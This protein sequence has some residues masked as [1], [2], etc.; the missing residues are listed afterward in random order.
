MGEGARGCW[1]CVAVGRGESGGKKRW[2]RI[3]C[4]E[5]YRIGLSVAHR[6][7]HASYVCVSVSVCMCVCV[8]G[9]VEVVYNKLSIFSYNVSYKSLREGIFLHVNS[10]RM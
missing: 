6:S 8:G 10:E 2:C 4:R 5:L 9:G 1:E 3:G 7:S